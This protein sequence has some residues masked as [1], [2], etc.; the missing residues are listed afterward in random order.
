M[1]L[2]TLLYRV[3]VL[4]RTWGQAENIC[5]SFCALYFVGGIRYVYFVGISAGGPP[6]VWSSWLVTIVC[7]CITA[8]MLAEVCSSIPLSGS[9]YIWAAEC[10]GSKY[11]RLVGF[12]VAFWVSIVTGYMQ[13]LMQ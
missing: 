7:A 11:G 4:H 12:I 3:Q 2:L 8:A 9:I 13:P 5:A 6:A 10:A 1:W